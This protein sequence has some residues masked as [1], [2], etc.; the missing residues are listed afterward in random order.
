M[1]KL[2]FLFQR[3]NKFVKEGYSLNVCDIILSDFKEAINLLKR[4]IP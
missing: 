3:G 2:V 1:L 4:D